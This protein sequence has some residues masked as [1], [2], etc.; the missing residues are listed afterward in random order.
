MISQKSKPQTVSRFWREIFYLDPEFASDSMEFWRARFNWKRA[1][2]AAGWIV[3]ALLLMGAC[4]D[5][6]L[7]LMTM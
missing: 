6:V 1:A 3:L 4:A 2:R 7:R 5:F